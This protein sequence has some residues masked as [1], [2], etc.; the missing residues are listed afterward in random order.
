M[1]DAKPQWRTLRTVWR[2][3]SASA[4]LIPII[5][6]WVMGDWDG[7]FQS[8]ALPLFT[9][10]MVSLFVT[11]WR[12]RRY[13]LA[14]IQAEA[15]G[16]EEGAKAAWSVLHREQM[17]GLLAAELPGFIGVIHFFCTGEWI[18]LLLLVLVSL[19]A[20]A[21]YRPPAAWVK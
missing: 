17:L 4:L 12:F 2:M 19:G 9:L 15:L 8:A 20:M 5:V 6:V 10:A 3:Q 7:V 14:L 16:N 11:L 21:L 18:P 13:K 1:F